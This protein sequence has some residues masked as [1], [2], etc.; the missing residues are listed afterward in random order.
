MG[1]KARA[2]LVLPHAGASSALVSL[3]K[4]IEAASLPVMP[5]Q[6]EAGREQPE[7]GENEKFSF[8]D[9]LSAEDRSPAQHF[10]SVVENGGL[11]RRR[12]A[13]RRVERD[14]NRA[15]GS[16]R[17]HGRRRGV[18]MPHPH[19]GPPRTLGAPRPSS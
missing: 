13:L 4:S 10:V 16:R 6:P 14:R 1:L 18:A 5:A 3:S 15:V 7:S 9:A 2:R 8:H 17:D 11:A 12:R 19:L